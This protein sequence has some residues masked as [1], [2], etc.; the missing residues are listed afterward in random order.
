[1]FNFAQEKGREERSVPQKADSPHQVRK[2][3]EALLSSEEAKH[4]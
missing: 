2:V 4:R 3:V 1:V